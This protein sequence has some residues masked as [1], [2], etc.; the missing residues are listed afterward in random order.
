MLTTKRSRS[1]WKGSSAGGRCRQVLITWSAW[2][3]IASY[4]SAASAIASEP[5]SSR[6]DAVAAFTNAVWP[7]TRN[8]SRPT[9]LSQTGRD[10]PWVSRSAASSMSWAATWRS[11]PTCRT[12]PESP[13]VS[14]A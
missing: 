12:R 7:W 4:P 5:R 13:E 11:V 1:S 8:A 3:A 14:W 6:H 9:T 10:R 2:P